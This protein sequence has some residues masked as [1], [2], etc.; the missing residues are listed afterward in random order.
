MK[1]Q[2]SYWDGNSDGNYNGTEEEKFNS[3]GE[4]SDNGEE[5]VKR[6]NTLEE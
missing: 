4:M 2:K 5:V 1:E 3:Q 6:R